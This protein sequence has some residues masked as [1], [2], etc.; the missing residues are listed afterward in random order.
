MFSASL[1]CLLLLSPQRSVEGEKI[2][3]TQAMCQLSSLTLCPSITCS[4]AESSV[5]EDA[6]MAAWPALRVLGRKTAETQGQP[7]WRR[8]NLTPEARGADEGK[9]ALGGTPE[10]RR[11]PTSFYV[12]MHIWP[13]EAPEYLPRQP[14]WNVSPSHVEG[15]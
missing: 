3:E 4:A 2:L 7:W 11:A 6:G 10:Q 5:R 14:D 9:D 1:L 8:S 15:M 13:P 12:R